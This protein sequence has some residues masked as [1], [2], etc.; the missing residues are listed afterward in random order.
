MLVKLSNGRQFIVKNEYST[1]EK[2]TETKDQYGRL[3]ITMWDE[4]ACKVKV[5]EYFKD[6]PMSKIIFTGRSHCSYQDKYSKVMARNLAYTRAIDE[7][8]KSNY[9]NDDEFVELCDFELNCSVFDASEDHFFEKILAKT[10]KT[11]KST[12]KHECC[13]R[14]TCGKHYTEICSE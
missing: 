9:I 7:M 13:N 10:P 14:C 4:K 12:C 5:Y 8:L 2:Y 1:I 3:Q 11:P 6:E